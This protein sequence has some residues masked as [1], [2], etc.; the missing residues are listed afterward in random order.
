MTGQ[1][2]KNPRHYARTVW[3]IYMQKRI[4]LYFLY[5]EHVYVACTKHRRKK[6]YINR[7]IK[8]YLTHIISVTPNPLLSL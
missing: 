1:R 3:K 8:Y 2:L 4:H 6:K 5:F 7:A